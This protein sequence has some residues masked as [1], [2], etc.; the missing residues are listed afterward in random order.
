MDV[1]CG[2]CVGCFMEGAIHRPA[3][4]WAAIPVLMCG[5]AYGYPH[6]DCAFCAHLHDGIINMGAKSS[7]H[8]G[9]L[10]WNLA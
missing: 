1:Q 4:R 5:H 7:N 6:E 8:M 3:E 2:A 10:M 9:W